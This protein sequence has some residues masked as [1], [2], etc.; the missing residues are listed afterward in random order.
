MAMTR[1]VAL[2]AVF[3]AACLTGKSDPSPGSAPPPPAGDAAPASPSPAGDLPQMLQSV[4]Q[5]LDKPGPYEAP[6]SSSSYAADKPHWALLSLSGDVTEVESFSWSGGV[7]D[8]QLR[9]LISR[10]R[11]LGAEPE[12]VG[13]VL[14][15][16]GLGASLPD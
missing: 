15:V 2:V 10:L 5:N 3:T 12:L 7:G 8:I 13:L 6:R 1:A 16:I 11:E 9:E 14:R 4:M